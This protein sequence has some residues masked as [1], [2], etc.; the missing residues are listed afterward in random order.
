[1]ETG[2]IGLQ[3]LQGGIEKKPCKSSAIIAVKKLF[4]VWCNEKQMWCAMMQTHTKNIFKFFYLCVWIL[5]TEVEKVQK[6]FWCQKETYEL[7]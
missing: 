7:L 4:L 2:Y 3:S 6:N 1:M 5:I